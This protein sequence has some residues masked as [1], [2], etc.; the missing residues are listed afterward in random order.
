MEAIEFRARVKDG[1]IEIP[2]RYKNKIPERVHV[3]VF[4][5]TSGIHRDMIDELLENPLKIDDFSP[6][7]REEIY[8]RHGSLSRR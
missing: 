6:L 3:I 1:K 7:T 5:Q 8:E 2:K 4:G